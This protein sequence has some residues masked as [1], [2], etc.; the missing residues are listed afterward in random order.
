VFL[1]LECTYKLAEDALAGNV[2]AERSVEGL[3]QPALCAAM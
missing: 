1:E 2:A 3:R